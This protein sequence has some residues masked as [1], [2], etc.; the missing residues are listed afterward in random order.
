MP[1]MRSILGVL[2]A[3]AAMEA[4]VRL[5]ADDHPS[6]DPVYGWS[7][8]SQTVVRRIGEGSAVS[9]WD[10]DGVR[11]GPPAPAGA[12][13]VLAI[14]DSF[15][16]A[17]QVDDDET[18]TAVAQRALNREGIPM[19]L[20]NAGRGSSS[21]ADYVA[22]AGL[23]LARFRPRWI[24]IQLNEGDLEG[25]AF[26]VGK[27][28]FVR[29]PGGLQ[30]ETVPPR[31][32]RFPHPLGDRSA[33]ANFLVAKAGGYRSGARMPPLFRAADLGPYEASL[34][35]SA[36]RRWPA[37]AI[38][39]RM[40]TAYGNRVTYFYLPGFTREPSQAERQ[41]AGWCR[42]QNVSCIDFRD[43]F[44]PFRLAGHAP[45]GFANSGHFAT[46]HLNPAGHAAAGRLLAAELRRVR[47]RGLF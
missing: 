18:F 21:P 30:P 37:E 40:R 45:F 8:R 32:A 29:G 36:K 6:Y 24:V 41:F 10:A 42:D 20:I 26:D 14:G 11:V 46:G 15:T 16:E 3:L 38:L 12:A 19:R 17:M 25:D 5:L 7:Y 2:L 9:H 31:R 22:R 28:H 43:A 39:D 1:A 44:S 34:P 23:D 4:L 33:L 35:D 27:T 47:Q 13:P